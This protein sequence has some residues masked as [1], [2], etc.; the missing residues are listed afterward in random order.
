M[1]REVDRIIKDRWEEWELQQ[2]AYRECHGN[3]LE[4][5]ITRKLR[6]SQF[7]INRDME[8]MM[9]QMKCENDDLQWSLQRVLDENSELRER[10]I[11]MARALEILTADMTECKKA[12]GFIG[13]LMP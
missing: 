10:Q 1:E 13:P 7:E 3:M 9:D 6:R 8:R 4:D 5:E 2:D 11:M 12:H